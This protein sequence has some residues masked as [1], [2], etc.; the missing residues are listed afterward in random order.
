MGAVTM[1]IPTDDPEDRE[2]GLAAAATALR[3]GQLVGL[4]LDTAY[5]I[6]ADAFSE[7][8]ILALR[9]A[10][11]R[12]DLAVPVMVPRIATVAGVAQADEA[13]RALMRD[14]W[15]GPLTLVLRAQPTLAWI[16]A[17]AADRIAVRMPL[18]PV[19]LE[20]LAR[21]GPL[22]VVG[23][24]PGATDPDAAYPAALA[25]HLTVLLDG[26]VLP[27][28]PSSTVVDCTGPAPVLVRPGPLRPADLQ[29]TC[30]DL[31]VPELSVPPAPVDD[32]APSPP[33]DGG[34]HGGDRARA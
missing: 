16:L 3:R 15:P 21:T 26:G 31:V 5:G 32:P 33:T 19:A 11:G 9:T 30:P 2:R 6:A 1:R 24:T 10:K 23:A 28:G 14:F 27:A 34:E 25:A 8:G 17:D 4:P 29:A 20:L 13:A 12:P 7:R 18:H 22:G